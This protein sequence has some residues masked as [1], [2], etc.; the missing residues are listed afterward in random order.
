MQVL[1][2]I[3]KLIK[4]PEEIVRRVKNYQ[5]EH[6]IS[7]FSKAVYQLIEKGLNKKEHSK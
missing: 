5:T 6:N 1:N 4:F 2:R 7:T 3:P